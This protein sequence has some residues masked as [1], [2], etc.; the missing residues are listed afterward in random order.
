MKLNQFDYVRMGFLSLLVLLT[1]LLIGNRLSRAG[2]ATS[3]K[4]GVVSVTV[5][6]I[7]VT[8]VTPN[9]DIQDPTNLSEAANFAWQEFIALT[10]PA[11]AQGPST[12]PRGM[13]LTDGSVPY[14][15]AGPTGQ[16]VFETFRHKVEVFPGMG[17]PNGY[18]AGKPDFGFSSIP[19]YTYQNGLIPPAPGIKN[20]AVPPY[21]NLDEVTQISLN[22]MYAGA[23][24]PHPSMGGSSQTSQVEKILFQA[25]VNET[26][27]D[28]VASN[29][30]WGQDVNPNLATILLN[31]GSFVQTGDAKTYPGPYINLPPSD[32]ANK[33]LVPASNPHRRPGED[34]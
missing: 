16:V 20:P 3:V 13:P 14:G 7:T 8:P 29:K 28:Y 27:Y 25:K 31:S 11:P 6:P 15:K 1:V 2:S 34:P 5:T 9:F 33:K 17:N 4:S 21:D 24:D 22:A 32:P 19:V 12:F 10:W 30:F 18:D 26:Q 23:V